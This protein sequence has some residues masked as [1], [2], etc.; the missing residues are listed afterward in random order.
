MTETIEKNKGG[1]PPKYATVEELQTGIDNYFEDCKKTLSHLTVTG[2]ALFLN[3]TRKGL[4]EYAE[5]S[6]EFGN[7]VK[8]AKLKVENY[9]EQRLFESN[10]AG[11]IFNLKNN[12]DWRD[13]NETELSTAPGRPLEYKNLTDD[14]LDAR[15]A[16]LS[17]KE[18]EA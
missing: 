6:D 9:I 8:M 15:I 18:P 4:I 1:R 2:L 17:A 3:M 5:K 11:C 14:E 10:P 7:A 12:F 13:R 16:E